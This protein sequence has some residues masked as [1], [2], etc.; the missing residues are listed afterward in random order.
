MERLKSAN[1]HRS[2]E[3][4]IALFTHQNQAFDRT[5]ESQIRRITPQ[6]L[7]YLKL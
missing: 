5:F 1:G 7:V 3:S 2:P 4:Q 6:D